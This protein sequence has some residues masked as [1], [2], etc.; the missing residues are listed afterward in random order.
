MSDK[1]KED[2]ADPQV[3]VDLLN[4]EFDI[5]IPSNIDK[6]IQE[7]KEM[8]KELKELES[9]LPDAD[10]IIYDNIERANRILD[11]IEHDIQNGDHSAR[12]LEVV[13]QLINAVTSAA[14]SITGISYN[15]QVIDHK[16]RM[17]DI[18]EKELAVRGIAK[19]AENVNITNNN[20]VMTREDLL[21]MLDE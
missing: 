21:K 13:G 20:L 14:T 3:N 18:K 7:V 11:T 16:N 4:S 17:L 5:E 10:Q 8:R 15:Q 9:D 19:G 6:T 2:K 12:L 1:W